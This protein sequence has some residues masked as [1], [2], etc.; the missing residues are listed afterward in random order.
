MNFH[1]VE[2]FPLDVNCHK[3]HHSG[4][5]LYMYAPVRW[6]V[7]VQLLQL[8]HTSDYWDRN[9]SAKWAQKRKQIPMNSLSQS[10]RV[11]L[12]TSFENGLSVLGCVR[13][14]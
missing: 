2:I 14:Y 5:T 1:S 11:N 7:K 10:D 9:M 6:V 8:C 12:L 13:Y 4:S 3:R